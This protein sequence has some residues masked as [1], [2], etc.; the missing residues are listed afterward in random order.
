M[1]DDDLLTFRKAVIVWG[2]PAQLGM[3]V[4]ECAELISDINRYGRGRIT[5]DKL[6]EEVV[7]VQIMIEQ[8]RIIMDDQSKWER[9][10]SHKIGRLKGKVLESINKRRKFKTLT[11]KQERELNEIEIIEKNIKSE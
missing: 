4:E 5:D 6:M 9:M 8:M 7:D 2:R 10:W 1:N 11:E 3:V